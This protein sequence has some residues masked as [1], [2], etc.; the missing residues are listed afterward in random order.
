ML[1]IAKL[2]KKIREA[3]KSRLGRCEDMILCHN[4]KTYGFPN[5]SLQK[6]TM[7]ISQKKGTMNISQKKGTM[8][9]SQKKGTM[10]ISQK[11]AFNIFSNK[12]QKNYSQK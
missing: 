2:Q 4:Q 5:L 6:D 8:N 3:D 10:N 1:T 7:N 11:T 12:N 9:I